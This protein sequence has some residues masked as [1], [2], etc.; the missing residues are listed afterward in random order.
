MGDVIS[1]AE[2][3]ALLKVRIV[4]TGPLERVEV[5]NGINTIRTLH[6]FCQMDLGRRIK[7]VWSGADVRGRDRMTSWDGSLT[8][9]NNRIISFIPINFWNPTQPIQHISSNRLKWKS[10]STGGVAGVILELQKNNTGTI[11]IDTVQ[12]KVK[13]KVKSIG[14]TPKTWKCGGLRKQIQI[15]RLPDSKDSN[16]FEFQLP[17]NELQKGDNPLYV[18]VYQEDGHMAWSS[19]IYL[20]K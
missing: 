11:E 17:I 9:K 15:Y 13:V 18:C 7:V 8:M 1:A 3:T 5:R 10:A 16:Y 4:G 12:R 19:P 14:L 20:V 6:P 2:S